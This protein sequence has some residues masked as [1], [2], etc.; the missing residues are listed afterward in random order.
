MTSTTAK[1][2]SGTRTFYIVWFGQLVSLV[3]TSLSWF[4]LS[5]FIF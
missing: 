3:G 5:I 1:E 4:G 2:R